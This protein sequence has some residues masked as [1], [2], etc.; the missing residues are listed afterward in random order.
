MKSLT[1]M[2]L[3]VML[4]TQQPGYNI[5]GNMTQATW[6]RKRSQGTA[7]PRAHKLF[8]LKHRGL[9]LSQPASWR[10]QQ[11]LYKHSTRW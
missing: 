1:Y 10:H 2:P 5:N 4:Q 8:I 9:F 7:G 6:N 3:H 11:R